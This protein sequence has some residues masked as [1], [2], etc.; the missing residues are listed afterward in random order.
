MELNLTALFHCCLLAAESM[1]R[2]GRGG[3][4]INVASI[5]EHLGS[6]LFRLSAYAA[7]KGGVENL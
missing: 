1:R 7:S 2:K 6:S 4:I 5:F 3:R